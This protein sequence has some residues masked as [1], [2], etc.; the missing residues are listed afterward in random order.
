M[1]VHETYVAISVLSSS[2]RSLFLM[3]RREAW[4]LKAARW[5]GQVH[6]ALQK[7]HTL[8]HLS[9]EPRQWT[10]LLW[11]Q[12]PCPSSGLCPHLLAG[13][14]CHLWWECLRLGWGLATLDLR[15]GPAIPH[16]V[17]WG[18]AI[19]ERPICDWWWEI[20]V[21]RCEMTWAT[22]LNYMSHHE[23]LIM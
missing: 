21:M 9:L 17:G 5:Q 22:E 1:P 23:S 3:N 16:S 11:S 6:T 20:F 12:K 19:P 7:V 13:N 18:L 2:E 10:L 14:L 15:V 8:E 4:G